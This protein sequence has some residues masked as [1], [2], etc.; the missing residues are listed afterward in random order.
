MRR[1]LLILVLFSCFSSYAQD[2]HH[3]AY[4]IGWVSIADFGAIG[5]MQTQYDGA[6]T[7]ST[8][9]FASATAIF[10]AFDV[11]KA[12]RITGAGAAG[13]DL[14]TTISAFTNSHSIVLT[15]N[16]SSTV[17]AKRFDYGTNNTTPI[18]N[19]IASL[20]VQAIIG[21]PSHNS[22]LYIPPGAYFTNGGF[23]I[24][25]PVTVMGEGATGG[26]FFGSLGPDRNNYDISRIA[27]TSATNTLFAFSSP[28]VI[29]QGVG[30]QNISGVTPTGGAGIS[31]AQDGLRILHS[32][33][34]GFWDDVLDTVSTEV[35]FDDVFF[36]NYVRFGYNQGNTINPDGGQQAISNCNFYEQQYSGTGIFVVR[37]GGMKVVNCNFENDILSP[38]QVNCIQFALTGSTVDA[39]IANNSFENYTGAGVLL[40]TSGGT[41]ADVVI[42]GNQFSP[43]TSTGTGVT[44]RNAVGPVT[45]VGNTF[46]GNTGS[47]DTAIAI[48]GA[49]QVTIKGNSFV[50]NTWSQ[51]VYAPS[52]ALTIDRP[53]PLV[54]LTDAA[55]IIWDVNRGNS[56]IINPIGGN[57]TLSILNATDGEDLYLFIKQDATG[58]RTLSGGGNWIGTPYSSGNIRLNSQATQNTFYHIKYIGG[59]YIA[60]SPWNTVPYYSQA[61]DLQFDSLGYL[62]SSPYYNVDQ[63]N[64]VL[65][66]VTPL[67][68]P[69]GFWTANNDATAGFNTATSFRAGV[70]PT[71]YAT[72]Y[73]GFGIL[74]T[75][76]S[77]T[78]PL[79]AKTALFE[80]NASSNL[81][82]SNQSTNAADG[83]VFATGSSRALQTRIASNG[84]FIAGG[85]SDSAASFQ[86]GSANTA[87]NASMWIK[88][89]VVPMLA[90][91]R[92]PGMINYFTSLG[93]G[94]DS[95]NFVKSDGTVVNLLTPSSVGQRT[96][97]TVSSNT[98]FSLN[99]G[100]VLYMVIVNP[101][102]TITGF[103]VGTTSSGSD[104]ISNQNLP[105][106]SNAFTIGYYSTGATTLY[107]QGISSSTTITIIRL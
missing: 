86:I 91:N 6:I 45:I 105:S 79:K 22:V 8:N 60:T 95:L 5:D 84:N 52:A 14:L 23:T 67:N 27:S 70:D 96:T 69:T 25:V 81:V 7:S 16:A 83:I 34:A 44:Q 2:K 21:I 56:A 10:T 12:I 50:T 76:F 75:G 97:T 54:T 62:K 94:N 9:T 31:M 49:P 32:A 90:G 1:L 61:G 87:S 103:Q 17:S 100:D 102:S 89:S 57:R 101:I 24:P 33:V 46:R 41:F 106:G 59:S 26:K 18:T 39:L 35:V 107:F 64:N 3:A 78:G 19:A 80:A 37:G 88:G 93:A 65:K 82:I 73:V 20:S 77:A 71:S 30:F 85:S 15:S 29:I 48:Y 99:T 72:N 43:Y 51:N 42:A 58:G 63:T 66:N 104:I 92:K 11:G 68:G 47:T 38:G 28:G 98:T 13:A 74:G 55:T 4:S 36:Y 53:E 40:G